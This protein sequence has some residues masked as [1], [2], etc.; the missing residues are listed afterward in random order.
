MRASGTD[1][2]DLDQGDEALA[3]IPEREMTAQELRELLAEGSRE[4]RAWAVSRILL[5]AEWEE[6]WSYVSRDEITELFPDLDLPP[7]LRAA[8]ARILRLEI[9]EPVPQEG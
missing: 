7:A 9:E 8:W 1:L 6:I 3:F 2:P 4:L 5:Y